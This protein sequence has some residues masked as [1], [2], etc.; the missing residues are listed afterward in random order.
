MFQPT[1]GKNNEFNFNFKFH[2]KEAVSNSQEFQE[3]GLKIQSFTKQ[4]YKNSEISRVRLK[5]E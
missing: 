3:V 5:F 2:E 4:F 1:L